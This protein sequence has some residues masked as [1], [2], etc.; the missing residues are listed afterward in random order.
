MVKNM[1]HCGKQNDDA[2]EILVQRTVRMFF[3]TRYIHRNGKCSIAV[4]PYK[5]ARER[6]AVVLKIPDGVLQRMPN[7]KTPVAGEIAL[8][9]LSRPA[10]NI[11][12]MT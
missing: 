6:C 4:V 12:T 2:T 1:S 3:S 8:P 9:S 10:Q 5:L 7:T 11:F